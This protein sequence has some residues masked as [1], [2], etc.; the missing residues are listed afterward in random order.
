MDEILPVGFI[1]PD[2]QI[3]TFFSFEYYPGRTACKGCSHVAV[4]FCDI[5]SV[6]CNLPAVILNL[7]LR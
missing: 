3:K 7:Y 4:Y 6:L 1:K 2:H 5:K